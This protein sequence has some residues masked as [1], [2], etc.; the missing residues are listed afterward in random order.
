MLGP[1]HS[2]QLPCTGDVGLV[3]DCWPATWCY[4][5]VV[6]VRS[7]PAEAVNHARSK[8]PR[9]WTNL[10]AENRLVVSAPTC[11]AEQLV[12]PG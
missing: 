7:G 12:T 11:N 6:G 5:V 2:T 9:G 8:N 1:P 4:G 3:D 10:R